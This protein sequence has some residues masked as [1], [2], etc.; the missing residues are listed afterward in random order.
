MPKPSNK[1]DSSIR[2]L[3]S[4]SVGLLVLGGAMGYLPTG[5]T[6]PNRVLALT[7]PEFPAYQE[8][9]RGLQAGMKKSGITLEILNV[10]ADNEPSE[11]SEH[12][13]EFDPDLTVSVG[14][15]A[16]GLISSL[17]SAQPMLSTMVLNPAGVSGSSQAPVSVVILDLSLDLVAT[18]LQEL[19][20]GKRRLGIIGLADWDEAKMREL[21]A[22]AR[23]HGMTVAFALVADVSE[24]IETFTSL[25]GKVDFVWCRP[26]SAL[27]NSTTVTPLIRRSLQIRL[28][29]VGFSEAFV[30]SGAAVGIYP[31]YYDVGLQTADLVGLFQKGR[32]LPSLQNPRRAKVAVNQRV[33]RL[34]GL[35]FEKDSNE[36]SVLVFR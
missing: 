17:P 26:I 24:L 16:L 10:E 7:S 29:I 22:S 23:R 19:F 8:A 5:R 34:L 30:R 21:R 14:S 1:R 2:R 18:K 9:V 33:L 20:P 25:R 3:A 15:R 35:K 27:Y 31:D 36:N 28:P 4:L 6:E 12:I 11:I 32:P 13:Q